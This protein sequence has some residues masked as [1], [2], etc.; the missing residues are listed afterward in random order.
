MEM[1]QCKHGH[2]YDASRNAG[3]PY[4]NGNGEL[5]VTRPLGN[6]AEI[7]RT[8]SG[9]SVEA[10]AF[11]R[12]MPLGG[13]TSGQSTI[14]HTMPLSSPETNKTVA[15]NV[16]EQGIDPVRGWFVCTEGKKR[17]KDFRIH[18]EKNFIGRSKNNDICID[19]DESVSR[20]SHA[21]VTYDVRKN[22]FWFQAGDGKS[23][24]YVNDDIVLS[25][26]ELNPY[27]IAVIGNT[28]LM[29]VPFCCDNFK[30]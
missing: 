4:C 5:N 11:P 30:W 8:M 12:T 9:H 29:F 1:I 23:N 18:S 26:V 16:N 24:V 20:E 28:Q 10:P 14:P 25:P 21:V 22:R 27:D 19:F 3:C 7:N 2:Y 15:L 17:G 6:D 13:R